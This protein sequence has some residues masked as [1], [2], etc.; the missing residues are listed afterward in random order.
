MKY[1]HLYKGKDPEKPGHEFG[2]S[3]VMD[4]DTSTV[5]EICHVATHAQDDD[6]TLEVQLQLTLDQLRTLQEGDSEIRGI[7]RVLKVNPYKLKHIYEQDKNDLAV[8]L[9][10][11]NKCLKLLTLIQRKD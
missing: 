7:T 10:K 5:F 4:P 6:K 9:G 3:L 2:K 11:I 8:K 1:H